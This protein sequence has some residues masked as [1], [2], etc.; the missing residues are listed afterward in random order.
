M[1]AVEPLSSHAASWAGISSDHASND[2]PLPRLPPLGGG[3]TERHA[4]PPLGQILLEM[5]AVDPMHLLRAIA[6][7]ERSE[8]PLDDI[9]LARGWIDEHALLEAR[10]R[11][12]GCRAIDPVSQ[13]P[14]PRLVDEI[15]ADRCL[16]LGILPWRRAGAVTVVLTFRPD[17]FASVQPELGKRFGRVVMALC[18]RDQ[19][20]NAV[21]DLRGNALVRIAE[22]CVPEPESCRGHE[23]QSAR[24]AGVA[25][26][27]ALA[28][29]LAVAPAATIGLLAVWAVITLIATTGLK[30]ACLVA[31]AGRRP[32]RDSSADQP[33][34]LPVV[35][36]MVPLFREDDIAPRLVRRLGRID[37]PK[38]LL[39]I[40]L[41]VE[42]DD[43]ETRAVLGRRP[44]PG[45]MRVVTV[46][47][48]ALR[49]KPRALNYALNLC[50][51]SIIGVWDA[52]DA[53]APDQIR[54]VVRHFATAAPEVACLQGILDFYNAGHNW[55]TRCFAI[56]YAAW[57]RAV[58]PGLARLGLVVPLGGTT[59]FFRRSVLERIGAWDAHNVTEDADLGI[60]LA[61]HGYRTELIDTVTQEEP[62]ARPWPWIRQRSRWQK[63]YAVTWATHMRSPLR[64]WRELGAWK[65][66]GVQILFLGS[67]SQ[68]ALAPVL[69]SF[70]MLALGLP[71]PLSP[72]MPGWIVV[73]LTGLFLLAEAANI[74]AGLWATRGSPHRHLMPWVPTLHLY[75]PLAALSSYKALYEW[76][77]RPF[78]WDKTAHGKLTAQADAAELLPVLVLT[79]PVHVPMAETN[80][81]RFRRPHAARLHL[82][83]TAAD[84]CH[85][86][87]GSGALRQAVDL[88]R[89]SGQHVGSGLP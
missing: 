70:W 55:L 75:F 20:E 33:T 15:G 63:G 13:P 58:L 57:F 61:R 81:T 31:A 66:M 73:A 4:V 84:C 74:S 38:E 37:Y 52:E 53:P 89:L 46:P 56:E 16:R 1:S 12:W 48:G 72:Y 22:T 44:L 5:R 23:G 88:D 87:D 43:C 41:V 39:D 45:W 26:I 83:P 47:R 82:L 8:A 3:R 59:L 24:P 79:N 64:L 40:L 68:A 29:G 85:V 71:H 65:F 51:G 7:R 54:K 2:D 17:G 78:F 6:I 25:A 32:Q 77:T 34:R 21:I 36:V 27:L 49:T 9:L 62:N 18:R 10:C 35:S 80:V 86:E 11:Q 14:D 28:A 19:L 42:E 67:L 30:L 60:R 76:I 50:R 69:W